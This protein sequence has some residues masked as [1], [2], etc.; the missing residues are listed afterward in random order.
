MTKRQRAE[1]EKVLLKRAKG[2]TA[3]DENE[4]YAMIDGTLTLVK[5]KVS[6]REVSPD[7]SAIKMLLESE[8]DESESYSEEQLLKERDRLLKI[9][10]SSSES[11]VV[12]SDKAVKK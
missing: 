1:L 9:L 4:E 11:K 7:L 12:E 10:F 8:R 3:K 6:Y 2:Y 5:Q